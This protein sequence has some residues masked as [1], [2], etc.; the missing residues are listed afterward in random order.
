MPK[1]PREPRP[2]GVGERTNYRDSAAWKGAGGPDTL[3]LLWLFVGPPLMGEPKNS[4]AIAF[5]TL[6][7]PR[8]LGTDSVSVCIQI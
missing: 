4:F 1:G 8:Y 3:L 6:S 2:F 7:V 5:L